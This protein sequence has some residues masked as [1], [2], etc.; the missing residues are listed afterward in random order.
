[1]CIAILNKTGAELTSEQF[2]NS[3]KTNPHGGGIGYFE[4]GK[5]VI[6]K[7]MKDYKK[8]YNIYKEH[9]AKTKNPMI[10]H[11]RV[12]T[13]GL[14]DEENCHPFL[15]RNGIILAHNGI[16]SGFTGTEKKSDTREFCEFF[17]S[18]PYLKEQV[19]NWGQVIG[20][21]NKV[22]VL[23]P[24]GDFSIMNEYEG[25][26]EKSSWYSNNSHKTQKFIDPFSDILKGFSKKK[27]GTKSIMDYCDFCGEYEQ[28][29]TDGD[30]FEVCT[31]CFT[32][33]LNP[34]KPEY[35]EK[36]AFDY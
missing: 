14:L 28:L 6:V 11:F 24:D 4:N 17:G 29:Y 7:E 25:S 30:K 27:S 16:L 18:I 34:L 20:Y 22:I 13:S 8:F 33:G 19:H 35:R 32:E 12:G 31:H 21:G 5:P 23:S 26:W 15:C 36:V 3:W 1:M 9:R 10:V 2:K